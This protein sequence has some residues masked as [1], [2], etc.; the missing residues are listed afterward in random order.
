MLRRGHVVALCVLALLTLGVIMVNSATMT[1]RRD[2]LAVQSAPAAPLVSTAPT[3][4]PRSV[5]LSRPTIYMGL[6]LLA[7]GAGAFVPVR[8]LAARLAAPDP[9]LTSPGAPFLTGLAPVAVFCVALI[10]I[11][12]LVYTPL[13]GREINGAHRWLRLPVPG[14]GD[15]LSMQPSEIA[16]WALV[17]L[18][19]WYGARRAAVM[20]RFWRG[21]VPALAALGAVAGF[22]VLEDLGTGVLIA[23][24]ACIIL[25]AA[26][27][28]LWHFAV[29]I[30]AG[31]LGLLAAIAQ[32]PYRLARITAFID[33]YLDPKGIG[34]HMI[35]S[36][37]AVAGGEG[38]GRGLGHGTQKFG[39]L[40][41][42]QNDFLFAIV[43][44]ELGIAGAGVVIGLFLM[45]VWT[46]VAII[47]RERE[48]FL[49]LLGLG[50]LA[51]VALQ[52]VINMI[53]VTGLGPTKGIALP[54][55]SAGGTGWIL[56][57]FSLGLLVAID[58][59]Q[60]EEVESPS[61]SLS[62]LLPDAEAP[63]NIPPVVIGPEAPP[64]LERAALAVA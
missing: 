58:R 33:P 42:D 27:A 8:T 44:E 30:P 62:D 52:A 10:A 57:A 18:F 61:A 20:P 53:V 24:A 40:P 49:K 12:A 46:G 48:P 9:R 37:A 7:L 4:T 38:A 47:R 25:V 56:T 31:A 39:Y 35:Q 34:Y 63:R 59:T 55:V 6:A 60:P 5:L 14:L 17:A 19:A 64:A 1:V 11:M 32:A 29:F 13:L 26:G 41:E 43:C 2:P 36:M 21:L 16:K 45:L 3:V 22:V 50:V 28:R 15:A 51:T 23:A 54:L